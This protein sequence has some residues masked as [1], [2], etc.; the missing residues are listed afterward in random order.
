MTSDPAYLDYL[1]DNTRYLIYTNDPICKNK[2]YDIVYNNNL[3]I[4]DLANCRTTTF[5]ECLDLNSARIASGHNVVIAI[6]AMG[7]NQGVRVRVS[8]ENIIIDLNDNNLSYKNA[9]K[10][11]NVEPSVQIDNNSLNTQLLH[12]INEQL[13]FI[14]EILNDINISI[15]SQDD[16]YKKLIDEIKEIK[17][18]IQEK[19]SG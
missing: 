18:T 1:T 4:N 17:N 9:L 10:N 2:L 3:E 5:K 19:G 12:N 15:K 14:S 16:S 13:A 11:S 7:N 8:K 6:I